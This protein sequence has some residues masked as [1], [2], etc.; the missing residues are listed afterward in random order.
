MASLIW[1]GIAACVISLVLTWLLRDA[2][3]WLGILDHPE[4]KRKIHAA[5]IPR[6]GGLAIALAYVASILAVRHFFGS[7]FDQ[8]LVLVWKILTATAVILA[9]GLMDDLFG[10]KPWQ[11]LTGQFVGAGIACWKGIVIAGGAGSH[12][13]AWWGIPLTIVWL[14]VCS[15]AFNLVDGMDGLAAGLGLVSTVAMFFGAGLQHNSQL[16][17]AAIPLAGALLGFLRYNFNPATIF[18]GDSGSLSLGFVL[19]CFSIVWIGHSSTLQGLAAPL[20]AL[21]I[22]LLD[23]TLAI[24]RRLLRGQHVFAADRRHIHHRLLDRGMTP[25]KAVLVLYAAGIGVSIVALLHQSSLGNGSRSGFMLLLFCGTVV[26]AIRYLGYSEFAMAGKMLLRGDLGRFL[27]TQIELRALENAI[28]RAAT[29]AACAEAVVALIEGFGCFVTRVRFAGH[30]TGSRAAFAM[31]GWTIR[32][33]LDDGDFIELTREF[34]DGSYSAHVGPLV[35]VLR[36][37]LVAKGRTFTRTFSPGPQMV[38]GRLVVGG[39]LAVGQAA[40]SR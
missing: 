37:S 4:G 33:P 9:V 29:P 40:D 14:L 21:S 35:D 38:P 19:G 17:L 11:K 28:S 31:P 1:V 15:N 26:A 36:G 25:K 30:I 5:P 2:F 16:A 24:G 13:D 10:L 12:Q 23:V 8:Q 3:R 7:A 22:P 20:I 39:E 27:A 18:L 32:V 34:G 6:G